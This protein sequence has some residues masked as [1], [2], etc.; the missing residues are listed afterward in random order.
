[1]VDTYSSCKF[2]RL[3]TISGKVE[4][5]LFVKFLIRTVVTSG[6]IWHRIPPNS[7]AYRIC[8]AQSWFEHVVWIDE[9]AYGA[10]K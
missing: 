7:T 2:S 8:T 10:V 6:S 3:K 1:M 5:R 4:R 9:P